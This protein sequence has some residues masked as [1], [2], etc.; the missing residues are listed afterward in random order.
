MKDEET[1]AELLKRVQD[2]EAWLKLLLRR[3]ALSALEPSPKRFR[4][5][6][7]F[8]L[9]FHLRAL[10]VIQRQNLTRAPE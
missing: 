8:T 9:A 5:K 2:L 7:V 6:V 3:L 10:I 4:S 1:A